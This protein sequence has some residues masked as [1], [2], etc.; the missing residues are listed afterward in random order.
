MQYMARIQN[1]VEILTLTWMHTHEMLHMRR[2]FE[3]MLHDK[4]KPR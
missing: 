3:D 1:C 4:M 2:Q